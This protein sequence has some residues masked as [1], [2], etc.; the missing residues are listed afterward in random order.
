MVGPETVG[1]G[2]V[3]YGQGEKFGRNTVL[4]FV[5]ISVKYFGI[6]GKV[7]FFQGLRVYNQTL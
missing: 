5:S 1:Y 7:C 2:S 4:F 6:R 3:R